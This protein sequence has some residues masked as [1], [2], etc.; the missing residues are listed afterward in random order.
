MDEPVS[1]DDVRVLE[2]SRDRY[3]ERFPVMAFPTKS[4]EWWLLHEDA[5]DELVATFPDVDVYKQLNLAF[6]WIR[7]NEGRRKTDRGMMRF[8]TGWMIRVR[9]RAR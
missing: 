4:G 3:A 8:I 7:G 5:Y 6:A 2:R 1:V 9:D